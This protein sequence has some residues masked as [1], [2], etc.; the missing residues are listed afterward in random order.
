MI[1]TKQQLKTYCTCSI[2]EKVEQLKWISS[3]SRCLFISSDVSMFLF[4]TRPCFNYFYLLLLLLLR[5]TGLSGRF[6]KHYIFWLCWTTTTTQSSSLIPEVDRSHF[7]KTYI[8]TRRE[9]PP[10]FHV[11]PAVKCSINVRLPSDN[12]NAC[13]HDSVTESF[14]CEREREIKD[15]DKKTKEK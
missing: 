1:P 11:G 3:G 15:Q 2:F 5:V 8:C 13:C 14:Q 9:R 7:I 12:W 10:S 4:R 6:N